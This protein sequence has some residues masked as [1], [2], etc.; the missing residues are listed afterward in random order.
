MRRIATSCCVG[1]LLVLLLLAVANAY[2]PVGSFGGSGSAD[3]Q[4]SHPLGVVATGA[5]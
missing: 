2:G 5:G 3:G 1:T 4:L